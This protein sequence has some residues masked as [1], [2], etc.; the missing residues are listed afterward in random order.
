[1]TTQGEPPLT[2]DRAGRRWA[3]V[4]V[5]IA[6][7]VVALVLAAL[8]LRDDDGGAAIGSA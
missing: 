8:V 7:L 5:F 2:R 1:M 3:V 4:A 6:V